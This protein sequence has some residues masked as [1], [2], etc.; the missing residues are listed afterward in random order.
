MSFLCLKA[1]VK[2]AR[3]HLYGKNEHPFQKKSSDLRMV[4]AK[5]T[6]KGFFTNIS[7]WSC[8]KS[9]IHGD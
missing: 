5:I 4:P 8:F 9:I 7:S 3:I 1:S 2:E 6:K